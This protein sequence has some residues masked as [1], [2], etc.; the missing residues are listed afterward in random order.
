MRNV[1]GIDVG[2]TFTDF[3]AYDPRTKRVRVWKE[4]SRIP[5]GVTSTYKHVSRKV[6]A[7]KA[8][9]AVGRATGQN[10][11]S[12]REREVLRLVA[13][14]HTY[15]SVGA[16]LFIAEKTVENHVRNILGKLHLS[17]RAELVR[18]AAD[19]GL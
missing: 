16:E 4:L 2:G 5:Y 14:G 9:Q 7:P 17:R 12:D 6:S 15:R 3:V 13:K 11:L 19:H 18:W 8:F 1:L 10:P